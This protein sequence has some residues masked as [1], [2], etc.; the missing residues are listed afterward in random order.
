M[1]CTSTYGDSSGTDKTAT[2]LDNYAHMMVS[3]D[4]R[5]VAKGKRQSIDDKQDG[6]YS[7]ELLPSLTDEVGY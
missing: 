3:K 1:R 4:A 2:T 7:Y 5:S 6:S